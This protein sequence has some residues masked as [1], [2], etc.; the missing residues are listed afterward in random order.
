MCA[1]WWSLVICGGSC[2]VVKMQVKH[3]GR[4]WLK[5][6]REKREIEIILYLKWV[7]VYKGWRHFYFQP[8]SGLV[9]FIGGLRLLC[10]W[11]KQKRSVVVCEGCRNRVPRTGRLQQTFTVSQ[12]WSLQVPDQAVSRVGF[13]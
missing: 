13:F 2:P 11:L 12:L 4:M 1:Y 7:Q 5:I 9:A 3:F 8:I 10:I 6:V